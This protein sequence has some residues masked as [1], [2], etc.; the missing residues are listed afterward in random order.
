M[1][2]YVCACESDFL[3]YLLN[4]SWL[5]IFVVIHFFPVYID[6]RACQREETGSIEKAKDR[7]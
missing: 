5:C 3:I 1:L 7:I 2:G 6:L 4:L